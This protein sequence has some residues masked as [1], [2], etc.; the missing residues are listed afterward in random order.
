MNGVSNSLHYIVSRSD[1]YKL[2]IKLK[3][4]EENL[5]FFFKKIKLLIRCWSE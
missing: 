5:D 2:Q 1:N 4:M 3:Y